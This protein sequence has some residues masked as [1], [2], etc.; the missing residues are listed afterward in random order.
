MDD[1][2][3][4]ENDEED[5]VQEDIAAFTLPHPY[6]VAKTPM[7]KLRES[8]RRWFRDCLSKLSST[9]QTM[10]CLTHTFSYRP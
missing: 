5:E 8:M 7:K 4:Q 9:T 2:P 3:G 10:D 1:I 6:F